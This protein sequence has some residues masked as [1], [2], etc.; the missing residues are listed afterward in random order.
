MAFARSIITSFAGGEWSPR[1]S[2][3]V[4]LSRYPV[5]CRRAR[6]RLIDQRGAAEH[7]P[8]TRLV[9]VAKDS[10][11]P[12][13]LLPFEFSTTQTYVIALNAGV[14]RFFKDKGVIESAPATPV[15]V[16]MPW[17]DAQLPG[18]ATT[19]SAD[20]LL[21]VHPD[22]SPKTLTRSSHTAWT[23]ANWSIEA[24]TSGRIHQ[25]HAKYVTREVTL[26]RSGTTG[27]ITLTASAAV[28][29]SGHV[30]TRFR[31]NGKEVVIDAVT[32]GTTATATVIETLTG[33]NPT[34]DWTEQAWSTVRGWPAT[35][36]FHNDRLV[37]G[38]SRDKR[39]QLWLSQVADFFN[40]DGGEAL[41]DEAIDVAILSDSVN[42][43]T[44]LAASD[45]H[46][47]IGTRGG[48]YFAAGGVER[49]ALTPSSINIFPASGVHCADLPALKI[50]QGT[51]FVQRHGRQVR[52]L[53]WRFEA[54]GYT[55]PDL[56]LFADH[57]TET[58][59]ITGWAYQQAP[60][61][62]IWAMLEDGRLIGCAHVP[63]QEVIA[64]FQ[65]TLAG[66]DAAVESLCVIPGA[67]GDELWLAVRRTVDG[68]TVRTIEVVE[69]VVTTGPHAHDAWHLD[70]AVPYDDDPTET[71]AGLDHLEGE[72]VGIWGDG[73]PHPDRVVS[74]GAVALAWPLSQALVGLRF[75]SILEPMPIEAGAQAGTAQGT[76][77][78]VSSLTVR[79][80]RAYGGM[81]GPDDGH[82]EPVIFDAS[83]DAMDGPVTLFSGDKPVLPPS[84]FGPATVVVRQDL[85]APQRVTAIIAEVTA[86]G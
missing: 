75:A 12:I 6:N 11:R 71:L 85:P 62:I 29:V 59:K 30:L 42:A 52:D 74:G 86:H 38:G 18:I 73:R 19:Q 39:N 72:T 77:Q 57:L 27:T 41:D 58:A 51:L 80:D 45:R 36:S 33:D 54:D 69:R 37:V 31:L 55:A 61:S 20:T 48:A 23:L 4:D 81:A 43:I 28:F 1:L 26:N 53:S 65:W 76:K 68:A 82:M 78:R 34:K 21:L 3:R 2:G 63:E 7:R 46:L 50:N 25:P 84:G 56:L 47:L 24:A 35:V 16:A 67:T 66:A 5:A 83:T 14:A 40:W 32:N 22:V 70:A 60:E 13:R 9:A 64:W 10:D 49:A 8:G 17:S 79:F 15:E 44:W